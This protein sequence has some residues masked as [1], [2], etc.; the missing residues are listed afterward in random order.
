MDLG[1][2][3]QLLK[4]DEAETD[5]GFRAEVLRL[6]RLGMMIAA[7]AAI[8]LSLFFLL[9]RFVVAPDPS[10]L[11]LRLLETAVIVSV[12]T[13]VLLIAPSSIAFRHGRAFAALC[14]GIVAEI[15]IGFSLWLL[16]QS[17]IRE[18]FIPAQLTMVMLVC[19]AGVPFRPLQMLG[20]G[21]VITFLYTASAGVFHLRAGGPPVQDPHVLYLF[22]LTLLSTALTALLYNQRLEN[23]R[24][25]AETLRTAEDL[26]AA[27]TRVL[28]SENAVLVGRLAAALSHELNSPIG[29]LVS[30]ADTLLLLASRQAV[31]A[32]SEQ[33]RLVRLQNEVRKSIQDSAKRLSEIAARMQRFTNLDKAETQSANLNDLISDV[34]ALL[35]PNI[36]G[37]ATVEMQLQDVPAFRCRPQQISAVLHNLLTNAAN[38]LDGDGRIVVA[39]RTMNSHIEVEISDNG[40]G[41]PS[42]DAS[43]IFSP[44]FLVT[45]E[46]V[47]TG[48]WGMFTARQILR[49]H[50]GD[51]KITK[52]GHGGTTVLLTV[53]GEKTS[54]T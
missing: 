25:H 44:N 22:T 41:V 2:F 10:S 15:I 26:R 51:I 4:P 31:S 13:V 46:R 30:G 37:K 34:V 1:R 8:G 18:D 27:Q 49:E 29:A 54:L 12:G 43:A 42:E 19:V 17:A 3:R 24:S 45:E 47:S 36:R 5:P 23:Y 20:L 38:A 7:G 6:G 28:L 35:E 40:R 9:A 11:G 50:G 53:P 32:P 48:N 52:S 21:A 14:A 33:Q 16:A 39:T